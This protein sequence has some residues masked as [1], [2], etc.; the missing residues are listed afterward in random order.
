M[1]SRSTAAVVRPVGLLAW[2]RSA[3]LPAA[4]PA[5]AYRDWH[6][7]GSKKSERADK[8]HG[9]VQLEDRNWRYKGQSKEDAE[10]RLQERDK[11]DAM[12]MEKV[13]STHELASKV[14]AAAAKEP[15]GES[16]ERR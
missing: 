1:A 16:N 10:H 9:Y 8:D 12:L 3:A 14:M 7:A 6:R 2:A 5:K 11:E 4:N 15:A 13:A